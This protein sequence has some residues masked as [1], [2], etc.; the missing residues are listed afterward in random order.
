MIT[1]FVD[2]RMKQWLMVVV[3]IFV[4]D[5]AAVEL[6]PEEYIGQNVMANTL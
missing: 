1:N 3:I 5:G 4:T 6:N 2:A